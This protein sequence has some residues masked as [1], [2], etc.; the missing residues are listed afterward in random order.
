MTW[1]WSIFRKYMSC[2]HPGA[3]HSK[4][5]FID[6]GKF[7]ENY[8]IAGDYEFLL[9]K[10]DN[11]KTVFLDCIT[12]NMLSNG[13]SS[14]SIRVFFET[15]HAKY[16]HTQRNIL[17]LYVEMLYHITKYFLRKLINQ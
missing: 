10:K 6:Y 14:S 4:N 12:V 1:E 2:A 15:L 8:L 16:L 3:F 11:L 13:V 7:N 5:L 17:I 9:R